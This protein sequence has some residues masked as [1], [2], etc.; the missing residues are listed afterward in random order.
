MINCQLLTETFIMYIKFCNWNGNQMNLCNGEEAST[1]TKE[2]R[3]ASFSELLL[4]VSELPKSML[5]QGQAALIIKIKRKLHWLTIPVSVSFLCTLRLLVLCI[6]FVPPRPRNKPN[7]ISITK[8]IVL[9]CI[10]HAQYHLR[11]LCLRKQP[12]IFTK[13][14]FLADEE[15]TQFFF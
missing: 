3:V 9:P 15:K 10:M 14:I 2:S 11:H 5:S 4:Y 1:T 6:Y 13:H 8:K 7:H 12:N